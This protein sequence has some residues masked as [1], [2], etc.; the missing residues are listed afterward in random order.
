LTIQEL[1]NL[2]D[3]KL[4]EFVGGPLYAKRVREELLK[5]F[6]LVENK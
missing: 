3:E 1:N 2:S 6:S 5:N 4:E